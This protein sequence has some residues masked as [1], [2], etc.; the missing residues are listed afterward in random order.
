MRALLV[1]AFL[2]CG[3][4]AAHA[5]RAV[6]SPDGIYVLAVGAGGRM[7]RSWNGGSFWS[8][9][10][11]GTAD[12]NALIMQGDLALIATG[13]GR[14]LRSADAG[15]TWAEAAPA[16]APLL[17]LDAAPDLSLALTV[18]AG[19]RLLR[20][21]DAGIGWAPVSSGTSVTL[22]AVRIAAGAAWAVGDAGT[23]LRSGD[24][25]A[26][27]TPSPSPTDVDLLAVDAI[28]DTVWIA[29]RQGAVFRSPDG[30]ATWMA[31]PLGLPATIDVEHV[32]LA[33]PDSVWL[34]GGGGF[35]RISADGGATWSFARQPALAAIGAL[36]FVPGHGAGWLALRDADAVLSTTDAGRTW[37]VPG[38]TVDASAWRQVRAYAGTARGSTVHANGRHPGGLFAA[39]ADSAY[40]SGDRGVTWQAFAKLPGASKTNAFIVSPYDT[41][42]MVAAVDN[43]DRVI[44]SID[45][46]ATWGATLT[47]DFSEF[48][49]PLEMDAAHP[50][51]LLFAPEDGL[52]YRSTDF[53]ATWDTLSAPGFRSPCDVQILP[54]RPLE[55]WVG[56]GVTNMNFGEIW[57]STD[58]GLTF[59]KRFTS[60]LG[61]EIP[62]LAV[63]PLDPDLGIGTQWSNGGV[64]RTQDGGATWGTISTAQT[65]WGAACAPDDPG[66]LAFGLFASGTSFFSTNRGTN[67]TAY[68][69][70]AS[71]YALYAVDRA[72]WL[73][74]QSGALYRFEPGYTLPF[75]DVRLVTLNAP[76]GGEAW[77]GG[78]VRTIQWTPFNLYRVVLEFSPSTGAP[79]TP[80]DTV[81]AYTGRYDWTIP[82]V[83]GGSARVRVRDLWDAAG[84]SDES[85]APFTLSSSFLTFTP[86]IVDLGPV[87]PGQVA[88]RTVTLDNAGNLPLE[89]LSV[90]P[91]IGS[92]PAQFWA[93]RSGFTIP[94]GASDTLGISFRPAA[95]GPATGTF[96]I[97][98]SDPDSPHELLVTGEGVPAA[99]SVAPIAPNPVVG[100]S[101][102]RYALP[103]A[104]DVVLEIYNLQGQK[105]ATLVNGR[106]PAGEY[107]APFGPGV[108]MG[109]GAGRAALP[110]GVYFYR[111]RAGP[112][113]VQRKVVLLR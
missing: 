14:I 57:R 113:D 86:G 77:R 59:S 76:N 110:P 48:G 98:A 90:V 67:L 100:Q 26:T 71:N 82:A 63:S 44:R 68:P 27:W 102:I 29:G 47:R 50:D 53:G 83:V 1:L 46:G 60:S 94:P 81:A 106:Q 75:V 58:G 104:A 72:T 89:V 105:V 54:G 16:G 56:D 85:D 15:G 88:T 9:G 31:V 32:Q 22:R 45:G 18:G 103:A 39:I 79:W 6:A 87:A 70:P 41:L 92:G 101:L 107:A 8:P 36:A 109:G 38:G 49:T 55:V 112:L 66:V 12:L 2:P 37:T 91:P 69:L 95:L 62:A 11:L 74:T 28:G 34:A 5:Y 17:A 52:L 25:G 111:F 19:G 24:G 108:A 30:G 33:A 21:V 7:A 35:V 97:V 93:G 78:E 80:I 3:P 65:A 73:A 4:V 20:S 84:P 99:F 51:T 96:T 43:P 13:D 61:S 42:R 23:V 64:V 10:T 40:R